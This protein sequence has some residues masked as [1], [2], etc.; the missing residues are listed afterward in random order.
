MARF[1]FGKRLGSGGFGL[2]RSATRVSED[3][4]NVVE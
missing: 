3:G 4:S 2:V 1:R